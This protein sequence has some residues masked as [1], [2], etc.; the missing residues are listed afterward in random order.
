MTIRTTTACKREKKILCKK[1][2]GVLYITK[3]QLENHFSRWKAEPLP[4]LLLL[5]HPTVF[6][7]PPHSPL[8]CSLAISWTKNAR[9]HYWAPHCPFRSFPHQWAHTGLVTLLSEVVSHHCSQKLH[10]HN[11]S[12]FFLAK[13]E[14][15]KSFHRQQVKE[16][17]LHISQNPI[18]LMTMLIFWRRQAI[19]LCLTQ[20]AKPI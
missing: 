3:S 19:F 20:S 16:R 6:A 9:P 5:P 14:E 17:A 13:A 18:S 10:E 15:H 4:A 7:P 8:L 1:E 12:F 2:A 11:I